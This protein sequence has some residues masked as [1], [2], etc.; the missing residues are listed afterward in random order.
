ME[1][2][3][4]LLPAQP[5]IIDN[6]SGRIKAGYADD[7]TPRVVFPNVVGR[8]KTQGIMVGAGQREYY[9]GDEAQAK[10]GI[11]AMRYPV[12]HGVI[13]NWEDMEKIWYEGRWNFFFFCEYFFFFQANP[14]FARERWNDKRGDS[15]SLR[16]F[17]WK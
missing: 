7:E 12:E 1:E 4:Y 9:V 14:F 5:V 6:G 10:R 16:I 3:H 13:T 2:S 8:A 11:L 15:I 17:F